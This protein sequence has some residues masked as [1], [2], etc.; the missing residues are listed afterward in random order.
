MCY[1]DLNRWDGS[2][3]GE[4]SKREGIY[5]C[6]YVSDMCVCVYIYIYDSLHVQHRN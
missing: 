4:R 5:A 3:V 6:I 1:D 2:G